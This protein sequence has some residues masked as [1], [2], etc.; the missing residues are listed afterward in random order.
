MAP[1]RCSSATTTLWCLV[2]VLNILIANSFNNARDLDVVTGNLEDRVKV[3]P[4]WGQGCLCQSSSFDLPVHAALPF[5][6]SA[7]ILPANPLFA[8]KV[9]CKTTLTARACA[10][11]TLSGFAL[12]GGSSICLILLDS[13]LHGKNTTHT[14]EITGGKMHDHHAPLEQVQVQDT[15]ARPAAVV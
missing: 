8:T 15:A 4:L 11:V 7:R 2:A 1:E 14:A 6:A 9:S 12:M 5:Y 10:Q 13:L 3:C